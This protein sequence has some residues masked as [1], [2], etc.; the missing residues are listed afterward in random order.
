MTVRTKTTLIILVTLLIGIVIGA[1]GRGA[2]A[3][4]YFGRPPGPFDSDRVRHMLTRTIDPTPDQVEALDEILDRHSEKFMDLAAEHAS[5]ARTMAD[6][7]LAEIAPIL[8]E[9][10]MA[11][12]QEKLKRLDRLHKGMRRGG[13]GR[14]GRFGKPGADGENPPMGDDDRRGRR[15]DHYDNDDDDRPRDG[16]HRQQP[17]D[18]TRVD[19][20]G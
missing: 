16:R 18:S 9:D 12:L 13:P 2:L 8:S 10:Q 4:Y 6:S 20:A 3:W 5:V 11:R 15:G 1:A 7:M 17:V 19:T 14:G